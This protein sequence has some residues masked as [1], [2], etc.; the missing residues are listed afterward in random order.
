MALSFEFRHAIVE[1]I[2]GHANG[3]GKSV[4]SAQVLN[5]FYELRLRRV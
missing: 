1:Y 3:L 2:A 5:K 4:T